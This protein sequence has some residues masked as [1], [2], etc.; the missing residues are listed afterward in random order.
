VTYT[1]TDVRVTV[2]ISGDIDLDGDVDN[3]DIGAVVGSF[4]GSGGIGG[5]WATGDLDG[6][7]DVDNADI[8]IV[9]G[10]FTGSQAQLEL[11]LTQAWSNVPEPSSIA[12]LG[13][14]GL[15]IARRRRR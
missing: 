7:G 14:G 11:A 6:D 4:T 3:A 10:E 9:V 8:G 13:L 5:S 15:L 1:A 2:A 12:I